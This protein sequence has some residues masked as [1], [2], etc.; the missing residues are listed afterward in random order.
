MNTGKPSGLEVSKGHSMSNQQMVSTD[1]SD[2]FEI[3]HTCRNYLETNV[4]QIFFI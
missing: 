2:S 4:C 1:P 3:W